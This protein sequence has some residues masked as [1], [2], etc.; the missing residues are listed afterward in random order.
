MGEV[1]HRA[2]G[3]STRNEYRPVYSHQPGGMP[4]G[5]QSRSSISLL[6]PLLL[7]GA[8]AFWELLA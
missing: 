6:L 5:G 8:G 2:P 3:M 1:R 4:V 7:G